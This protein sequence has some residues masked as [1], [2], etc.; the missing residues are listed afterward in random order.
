MD[1]KPMVSLY[2]VTR[3]AGTLSRYFFLRGFAFFFVVISSRGFAGIASMRRANS[4]R[5]MAGS[6]SSLGRFD[7]LFMG[8]ASAMCEGHYGR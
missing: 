1:D 7:A 2:P 6:E 8:F 5:D 3:Q 4:S